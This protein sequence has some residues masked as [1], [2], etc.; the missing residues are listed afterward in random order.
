MSKYLAILPV[1]GACMVGEGADDEVV[2]IEGKK[3]AEIR[4]V[5]HNIEKRMN[6]LERVVEHAQNID[7]HVVGLQEVCPDQVAWLRTNYGGVWT[8]AALKGKKRAITGCDLPDGTHDYPHNVAIY[9]KGTDGKVFEHNELANPVAA[10]GNMVCIVFERANVPVHFCSVHLIS[11]DWKDPT[12]QVTYDGAK[13]RLEQTTRIKQIANEWFAGAKNHFG[14]ITGDFNGQPNSEPLDKLYDSQLRG[15]G[16]FTEY[17]RSGA[18]RDGAITSTAD[19]DGQP[20]SRKIDYVFF[21]TN[22][23]PLDGAR[24]RVDETASD[25]NMVTSK[26]MMRK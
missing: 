6:V 7:A 26:V 20:F 3:A 13:V 16:A 9:T 1:L 18:S 15:T 11:G 10:P 22:R 21:S 8:I 2:S 4:V 23:A 24:A 5:Q 17:N 12:T 25:H 19:G 14:I